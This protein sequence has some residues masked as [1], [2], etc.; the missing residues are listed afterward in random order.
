MAVR[1]Y[2]VLTSHDNTTYNRTI[3]GDSI[4]EN[5]HHNGMAPGARIAFFDAGTPGATSLHIPGDLENLL[6]P[7][8]YAL[9]A[10]MH[11]N[12]WGTGNPAYT[13]WSQ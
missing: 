4:A 5:S 11:S 10:R 6:F 9:G 7:D 1:L 3:A 13:A 2:I 8:P 12:S